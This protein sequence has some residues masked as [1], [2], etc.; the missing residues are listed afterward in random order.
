[1]AKEAT[2][3]RASPLHRRTRVAYARTTSGC[4][5]GQPLT[6]PPVPAAGAVR[7]SVTVGRPDRV[8]SSR[9]LTGSGQAKEIAPYPPD[10]TE[11][12]DAN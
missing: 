6:S 10:D 11:R 4:R 8:A 12:N 9:P 2:A 5:K 7:S 3:V 1:M